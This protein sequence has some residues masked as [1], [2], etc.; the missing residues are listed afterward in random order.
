MGFFFTPQFGDLKMVLGICGFAAAAPYVY[1]YIAPALDESGLRI[2]DVALDEAARDGAATLASAAKNVRDE[3]TLPSFLDGIA[4]GGGSEAAAKV[5]PAPKAVPKN[6]P[7]AKTGRPAPQR[8]TLDTGGGGHLKTQKSLSLCPRMSVTN[9]PRSSGDGAV[10]GYREHANVNGVRLIV[11][12]TD[13]AC[14]SSA[15][16]Q[17]N[18]KLHKG[19]DFQGNPTNG[20][21]YAAGAG[22][23]LEAQYRD[24]YGNYVLIDHGSGVYTR[25][26]HLSGMRAAV[27]NTV[28]AGTILGNMSNTAGYKVPVHLHYELLLGNYDNPKKGWGLQATNILKYM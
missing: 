5:E 17:R 3:G 23:V 7:A 13:M 20:K 4:N 16:G 1:P 25:Y 8:L 26:A 19:V 2:P 24:D 11:V 9:A 15:F 18:G 14:L 21:V 6:K 12:P 22:R 27:G 10:L 28:K